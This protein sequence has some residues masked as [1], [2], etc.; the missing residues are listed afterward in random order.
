MT[1]VQQIEAGIE[2]IGLLDKPVDDSLEDEDYEDVVISSFSQE[3]LIG[4]NV[5]T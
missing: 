2:R 1:I 3:D 4:G 5:E